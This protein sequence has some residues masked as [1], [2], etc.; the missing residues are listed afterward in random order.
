VGAPRASDRSASRLANESARAVLEAYDSYRE[1]FAAIGRRARGR[2]E[3]C[4]W[5]GAM[6]DAAERLDLYGTVIDGIEDRVREALGP[7]RADH[8]VW[9]GM[10]AVYSGLIAGRQD[11]EL[12]E[13]F[14]NSVTRRHF[15][16][17]GV[18][19]DIE[20]VDSDF[21]APTLGPGGLLYRTYRQARDAAGM[22]EAILRD[23]WF[24]A[25]YEDLRR[26]A[27]RAG[28]R[29]QAYLVSLG[30]TGPVSRASVIH[31]PFFRRK[32]A[33]LIGHLPL[34]ERPVPF[35]LALLNTERGVVVDAVLTGENDISILFSFTR[36]HFHVDLGP[37]HALVRSL[38]VLMPRKPTA[39][40]YIALGYHKHGKTELYR[41]LLHRLRDTDERFQLAPGTP[42]M[43]MI[44]FTMPG[45]D[46]VLK[47]IR[48]RFPA[49]K[50]TTPNGIRQ[51]YRL[52][53]KHDRAGRLVEAQ[54]FEHL[55]F[56]R[57]RFAPELL[58]EFRRNADRTVEVR[59]GQVV[60]HHAYIER[61]VTPLDLYVRTA[62]EEAAR[63]AVADFGQAVKDLAG[64]GI[65][66]GELLPKNFG[67]TRHG[68]VVCYDYD[69]LGLL[70]DF[71]FRA[72]PAPRTDDDDLS[73]EAWF[74][75]G[76][77]DLFPAEFSRFLGLPPDLGRLLERAHGELFDL[78]FWQEMQARVARGEI[79]DIFPYDPSRRLMRD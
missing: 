28:D 24:D 57:A 32:G 37:A 5:R 33:Y 11:W 23:A 17:V 29:L 35:A 48:D 58:Q 54:E 72:L 50:P 71:S 3:R 21:E 22:V 6:A 18:D 16:T 9:A 13:T 64:N 10:K 74:G 2:F 62:S 39:E 38:K 49:I 59:D 73:D 60:V 31:A 77:R 12:A 15:A 79:I 30:A 78:R 53:F 34:G 47:I 61:R 68:R 76:P 44:V 65:F 69:E 14:F 43:V 67:V 56:E 41:D 42:G 63:A 66:P 36:S 26:D 8:L 75:V 4:D 25:P 1:A 55:E 27:R 52:V 70:T 46:V 45:Y 40:L 7:R 19:G 20:F 51:N